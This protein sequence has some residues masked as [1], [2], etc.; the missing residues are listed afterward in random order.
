[1]LEQMVPSLPPSLPVSDH[2]S[3][4]EMIHT[5]GCGISTNDEVKG[6]VGEGSDLE[7]SCVWHLQG[8]AVGTHMDK[9]IVRCG[10]SGQL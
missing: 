3:Q 6:A 9:G 2:N 7:G 10:Q 4:R 5:D 8:S 1:M